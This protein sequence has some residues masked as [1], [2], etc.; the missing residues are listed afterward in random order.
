MT[1]AS[2]IAA[3]T[4]AA[5]PA[6]A[7]AAERLRLNELGATATFIAT[8]SMTCG[9]LGRI[10]SG[11]PPA[12]YFQTPPSVAEERGG[13]RR[14]QLSPPRLNAMWSFRPDSLRPSP[15]VLLPNAS[16]RGRGDGLARGGDYCPRRALINRDRPVLVLGRVAAD[17]AEV[18]ALQLLCELAHLARANT[19]PVDLDHRRD[20]R[21]GAAQEQLIAGVQLGAVDA[22][23]DHS[24][25]Q[26]F[27]DHR[28]QQGPGD[29]FE[30]V[31]GDGWRHEDAVLEHEQVLGRTFGNV[32]V[33]SEDDRLVETG[34]NSLGFR[35]RR[36]RVRT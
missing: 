33:D 1:S 9:A 36:L 23:F 11:R 8:N 26:L 17:R 22:A 24:L 4:P 28:H 3:R 19:A 29:A 10:H 18:D 20:L 7:W 25:A 14:G 32:A 6:A 15:G 27:L 21:A 34:L 2:G 30:D 13:P 12:L 16:Q 31:V 35:Q 5:I